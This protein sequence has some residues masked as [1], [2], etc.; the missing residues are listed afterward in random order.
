[1]LLL[2][3]IVE[4]EKEKYDII[5]AGFNALSFASPGA[6]FGGIAPREDA[7]V[8]YEAEAPHTLP[9]EKI[10]MEFERH[11]RSARETGVVDLSPPVKRAF[12][13]FYN[14]PKDEKKVLRITGP[15]P[16]EDADDALG[17]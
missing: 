9:G 17:D 7:S 10:N 1:M 12:E 15:L 6:F 4:E 2:H 11:R 3:S 14:K 8:S 5:N 16:P 13:K